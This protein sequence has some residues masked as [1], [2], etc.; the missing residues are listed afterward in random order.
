VRQRRVIAVA[1]LAVIGTAG[2]QGGSGRPATAPPSGRAT[3]T[4]ST[5]PA[6]TLGQLAGGGAALSYHAGYTV[7]Q[8]HPRSTAQ[9]QVWRTAHALRVDVVTGK[10]RATLIVTPAATFACRA[11]KHR[12]TCFRVARRGHAIP[13][14]FRLLA[15]QLFSSDLGALAAH[16]QSYVVTRRPVSVSAGALPAAG[17]F[18]VRGR[19][20]AARPALT[21]A[22]YCFSA[23][24]VLTTVRYPS[25]NTVELASVTLH[26]PPATA[27]RPYAHPTPLG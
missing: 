27:F 23:D 18:A 17:C 22:T 12:R 26:Q 5:S 3:P 20:G 21:A 16:L 8:R 4:A 25:G 1:A 9:W 10:G 19:H 15:Q 6:P 24:G 2:C 14:P 7:R 13:P 11:T